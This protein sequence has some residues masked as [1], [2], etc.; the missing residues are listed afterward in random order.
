MLFIVLL[1]LVYALS[2]PWL[3]QAGMGF[4]IWGKILI[5]LVLIG[6]PSFFMGMP[7]PL[8]L[9]FLSKDNEE[10]VPWAWGINGCLSVVSAS[11]A[12]ILAIEVGFS[13]LMLLAAA[14]YFITL[15]SSFLV[16]P[17]IKLKSKIQK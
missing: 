5:S 1:L 16:K 9:H 17:S 10:A 14:A 7:F 4:S 12:T 13:V 8:G 3:L 2:L 6:L 11:L 15:A